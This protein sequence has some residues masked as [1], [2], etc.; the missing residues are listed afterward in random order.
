MRAHALVAVAAAA[1]LA[2]TAATE[3]RTAP[4]KQHSSAAGAAN[5]ATTWTNWYAYHGT[6]HRAGYSPTMPAP[7]SG[8]SINHRIALD[9]A[10]YASPIVYNGVTIVATE[11]NSVYAFSPTF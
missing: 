4:T 6:G 5:Q 10:V 2:C 11:N 9:G 1:L 8:L 3:P 7:H